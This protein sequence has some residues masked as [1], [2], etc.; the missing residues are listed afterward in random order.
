MNLP[1]RALNNIEVVRTL[2]QA[3]QSALRLWNM[4]ETKLNPF[5][6]QSEAWVAWENLRKAL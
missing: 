6:V 2:S 1:K 5:P 3:E 4:S